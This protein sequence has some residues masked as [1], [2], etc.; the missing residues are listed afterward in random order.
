MFHAREGWSTATAAELHRNDRFGRKRR[1]FDLRV[2]LAQDLFSRRWWRG[3]GTLGLLCA[4]AASFAPGI[5]PLPVSS[6]VTEAD[7][8]QNH[9]LA[10]T[11]LSDRSRTGLRMAP[12]DAVEPLEFAPERPFIDFAVTLAPGDTVERMLTRSGAA[13]ADAAN[14]GAMIGRIPPGTRIA[15]RLGRKGGGTRPVERVALRAGLDRDLII[16]RSGGALVLTSRAI[17]VDSTPLRIRG[18]VGE[19]LYWSLRAAGASPET[20]A[21]YLK[22]LAEEIDVGAMSP[23][24]RFDLV[25]A[26]RRAATGDSRSGPLLYA[27]IERVGDRSLQLVK[28]SVG[29]RSRWIDAASLGNAASE[30]AGMI[31]PVVGRITSTFGYRVHPIL[32]YGRFH[33]GVDFGAS[34]GAP[35]VAAADGQVTGAGWAGGYGRQVRIAHGDGITTSYS[36]MSRIVAAPGSIVQR[37]EVIGYVGS[38]G[39]STGPHLHYE[40]IQ[41]GRKV[42]PMSVRVANRPAVDPAQVSAFK[43][44]LKELLSVGVR[45]S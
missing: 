25:L 41:N 36:H 37:G 22:A 40:V 24:D 5:D 28:W 19:G 6:R 20:A 32:R 10:V 44:R 1:P 42:D 8:L 30:A 14:A 12:T 9:A 34:W 3:L 33:S 26:N 7:P 31:W 15:V 17:V 35:I 45:R 38:S 21:E 13:Y 2:D 18:R 23:D 27:A 4:A 43:A 39:L 29:G 11:S 16:S